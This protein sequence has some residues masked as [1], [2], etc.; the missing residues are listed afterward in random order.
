MEEIERG[1]QTGTGAKRDSC[2]LQHGMRMN[3]E[4]KLN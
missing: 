4:T 1:Q 2:F 3:N